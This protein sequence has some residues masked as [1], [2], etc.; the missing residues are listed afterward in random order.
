M[1]KFSLDPHRPHGAQPPV[2]VATAPPTRRAGNACDL[3]SPGHQMHYRHQGE[4]VRSPSRV[5]TNAIV[6][7]SSVTLVLD[8]HTELRWQ[9]HEPVRLE[10]I[11]ELV[12]GKRVAYPDQHALRVGPYW[13]N[14]ATDATGWQD[15]RT[16]GRRA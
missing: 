6:D 11:L 14:C 16:A 10:R 13:F 5:V 9:H 4:A 1:A 8:D 12:P 3:Y 2:G 7:D 15:C